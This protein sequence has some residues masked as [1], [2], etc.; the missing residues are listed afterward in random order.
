PSVLEN[1]TRKINADYTLNNLREVD[2][3]FAVPAEKFFMFCI[4]RPQISLAEL[5]DVA[6]DIF[7]RGVKIFLEIIS[8]DVSLSKRGNAAFGYGDGATALDAVKLAAK[9]PTLEDDELK[10]AQ[11]VFVHLA[12]GTPLPLSSLDAAQKFIKNQLQPEAEFLSREEINPL[13]GEKVFAT[14]ICTRK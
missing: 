11:K 5:F 9:F 4:N 8:R 10:T 3:L 12:S 2:T 1:V 6:D 7:C 13:F 14:I